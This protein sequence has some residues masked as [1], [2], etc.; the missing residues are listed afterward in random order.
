MNRQTYHA[1]NNQVPQHWHLVDA[2]DQ[3]LGR[4]ASQIAVL[5]MGKHK[6]QY[7]PHQD[8][9]DFVVVTNASKLRMTGS[10][11]DRRLFETYSGYPG[12]RQTYTYRQMLEKNPELL[13]QRTVRRMLPRTK[14]GRQMLKKLKV[15]PGAEHPHQSQKPETLELQ[16]A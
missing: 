5:L 15:Y 1:K 9:G 6:P 14:L 7:T 8:V 4:L 16:S 2:S 3:I 13:L 12:G 10:K 11:L